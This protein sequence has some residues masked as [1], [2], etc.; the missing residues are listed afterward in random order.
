MIALRESDHSVVET[1]I[2]LVAK[3]TL[4]ALKA[5]ESLSLD[6]LLLQAFAERTA[7]LQ[8]VH[9]EAT[10][11]DLWFVEVGLRP[12]LI[13]GVGLLIGKCEKAKKAQ[14]ELGIM[15]PKDTDRRLE[16]ARSLAARLLQ[17]PDQLNLGDR[18][19]DAMARSAADHLRPTK[20]SGIE[21]VTI[22]SGGRS[23]TLVADDDEEGGE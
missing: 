5:M 12:V 6:T 17:D 19:V 9:R 1:A 16:S 23:V 22:S 8:K 14:L 4:V 10:G 2:A 13:A 11:R 3:Q 15:D 21:S 18:F 20:E 7:A